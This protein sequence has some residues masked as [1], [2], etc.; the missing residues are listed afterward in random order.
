MAA[1]ARLGSNFD[2]SPKFASLCFIDEMSMIM[3]FAGRLA[4]ARFAQR[5][6]DGRGEAP[7][8]RRCRQ[9][10]RWIVHDST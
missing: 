10:A 2:G 5:V 3:D 4:A 1:P 9:L 7:A 6:E 8:E